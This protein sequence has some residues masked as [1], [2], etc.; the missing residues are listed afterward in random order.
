[1]LWAMLHGGFQGSPSAA[2]W[3]FWL[4]LALTPVESCTGPCGSLA[5]DSDL[6]S[7]TARP[8]SLFL[9]GLLEVSSVCVGANPSLR[10]LSMDMPLAFGPDMAVIAMSAGQVAGV[11]RSCWQA[12][13][14]EEEKRGQG[15]LRRS[16][17]KAALGG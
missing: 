7:V 17:E 15:T 12:Q 5:A 10:C 8:L 4:P 16:P 3:V 13:P 6:C 11:P 1:M 9:S 14:G 2:A